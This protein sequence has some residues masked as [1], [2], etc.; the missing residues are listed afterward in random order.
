M[1]KKLLLII[2]NLLLL[3]NGYAINKQDSIY[4]DLYRFLILTENMSKEMNWVLECDSSNCKQYLSIFDILR[5]SEF[6]NQPDFVNI[7]FGIYK[8]NYNG[9]MDCGYYVLIKH[10]ESYKVYYQERVTDIIKE[11]IRIRKE[12]PDLISNDLYEAYIETII[13]DETGLLD[14][15]LRLVQ[16]IGHIEY[17][18]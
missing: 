12:N 5:G 10:N 17:Y 2:I 1:Q 11:L 14:G 18:H 13:D 7:P 16:K 15:R 8:F 3:T 4:R 9:C 6:P